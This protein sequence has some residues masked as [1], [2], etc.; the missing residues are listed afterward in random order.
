MNFLER[1]LGPQQPKSATTATNRLKLLIE[2]DRASISPGTLDLIREDI[3]ES[4]QR[5][6]S[7][8]REQVEV[9]LDG[10]GRLIAEVPLGAR[11]GGGQSF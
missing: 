8:N 9:S 4:I 11:R 2:Y 3:I 6:V 7:V 5:H 10:R 1:L